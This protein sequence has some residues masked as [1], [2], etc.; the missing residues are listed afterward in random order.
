[1]GVERAKADTPP[2][3]AQSSM[4]K[5]RHRVSAEWADVATRQV[6]RPTVVLACVM[7]ILPRTFE[8]R[9]TRL[10]S[11]LAHGGD[12]QGGLDADARH[13]LHWAEMVGT[14]IS[15]RSPP[16]GV[17]RRRRRMGRVSATLPRLYLHR[18]IETRPVC[19]SSTGYPPMSRAIPSTTLTISQKAN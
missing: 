5:R 15:R 11:M 3:D 7:W 18:H 6:K 12:P 2:A 19:N 17:E 1:M 8:V 10:G 13:R 4:P 14:Y 9:R 16:L